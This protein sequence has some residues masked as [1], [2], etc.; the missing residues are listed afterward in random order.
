MYYSNNGGATW[1]NISK[2]LPNLPVNTVVYQNGT[3]RV[4][5]GTDVGVYYLNNISSQWVAYNNKLPNVMVHE[6]EINYTNNKLV[7]ATYGRGIW[8]VDLVSPSP[9]TS[10]QYIAKS[11]TPEDAVSKPSLEVNV[12]PNPSRGIIQV[13]IANASGKYEI[14]VVRINGKSVGLYSVSEADAAN[15]TINLGKAFPGNYMVIVR[16]GQQ[17]VS[18][19]ITIVR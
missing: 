1:T 12:S 3:D 8:K 2:N 17:S 16:N 18:K 7:A 5:V 9:V 14:E 13:M 19:E 4:Y 11:V 15:Y 10:K 6:L